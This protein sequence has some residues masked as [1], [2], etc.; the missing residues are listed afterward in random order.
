MASRDASDGSAERRD[1]TA[2]VILAILSLLEITILYVLIAVDTPVTPIVRRLLEN[3]AGVFTLV[4]FVV[5][6]LCAGMAGFLSWVERYHKKTTSGS[7]PTVGPPAHD[8]RD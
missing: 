6:L 4:M 7:A 3:G 2:L 1:Y 8:R 5:T